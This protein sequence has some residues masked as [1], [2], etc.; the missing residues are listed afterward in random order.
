MAYD[1]PPPSE[2]M[3]GLEECVGVGNVGT[4]RKE[5]T[6]QDQG[7]RICRMTYIVEHKSGTRHII[8]TSLIYSYEKC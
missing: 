6:R 7:L 3:N 8:V 5:Y 2:L 4:E 1:A